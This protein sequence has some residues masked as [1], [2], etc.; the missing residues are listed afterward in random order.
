MTL[1]IKQKS[2]K[3]KG[4]TTPHNPRDL[5]ILSRFT[6]LGLT[7]FDSQCV[8]LA[9]AVLDVCASLVVNTVRIQCIKDQCAERHT[10]VDVPPPIYVGVAEANQPACDIEEISEGY[11]N[12]VCVMFDPC[13]LNQIPYQKWQVNHCH[14]ETESRVNSEVPDADTIVDPCT[15]VVH[16]VSAPL[17]LATVVNKVNLLNFAYLAL[18]HGFRLSNGLVFRRD[19]AWVFLQEF[20]K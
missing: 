10:I 17:A 2:P 19:V 3:C 11:S 7:C 12:V 1:K 4:L 8:R 6:L 18:L 9:R 16:Q 14:D 5:G 20:E 13:D 15:V